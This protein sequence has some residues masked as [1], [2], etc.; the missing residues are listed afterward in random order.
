MNLEEITDW[1]KKCATATVDFGIKTRCG[2]ALLAT[3]CATAIYRE[4]TRKTNIAWTRILSVA[5]VFAVASLIYK[6]SKKLYWPLDLLIDFTSTIAERVNDAPMMQAHE[7]MKNTFLSSIAATVPPTTFTAVSYLTYSAIQKLQPDKITQVQQ[8][9]SSYALGKAAL[10]ADEYSSAAEH[11][12]HA[13]EIQKELARKY[14]YFF[15]WSEGSKGDVEFDKYIELL[16]WTA[17]ALFYNGEYERSELK[18]TEILNINPDDATSVKMRGIARMK[19]EKLEDAAEDFAKYI[20][21]NPRGHL[22]IQILNA[23]CH[24]DMERI[25]SIADIILYEGMDLSDRGLWT[26]LQTQNLADIIL[27]TIAIGS[28]A[29]YQKTKTPS[30]LEMSFYACFNLFRFC[31]ESFSPEKWHEHL[32]KFHE[33]CQELMG[34]Y[35][36]RKKIEAP[37]INIESGPHS[38]ILK[39]KSF[40]QADLREFLTNTLEPMLCAHPSHSRSLR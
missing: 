25:P 7:T 3:G 20:E 24:K 39:T 35:P 18:F 38:E 32:K 31:R 16:Y 26:T 22:E 8:R 6:D 21:L 14:T 33:T 30:H 10:E 23:F 29:A 37:L 40:E 2:R 1:I 11:F 36:R 34:Q 13:L 4:R 9:E 15:C 5:A 17:I 12:F 28:Y 27:E 19:L